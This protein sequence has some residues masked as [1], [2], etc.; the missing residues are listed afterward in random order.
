MKILEKENIFYDYYLKE[1]A[2]GGTLPVDDVDK[3]SDLRVPDVGHDL[4]DLGGEEPGQQLGVGDVVD[5]VVGEDGDGALP[6]DLPVE[7][8]CRLGLVRDLAGVGRTSG[9]AEQS[10]PDLGGGPLHQDQHV[11]PL[12]GE[13]GA[14]GRD[15]QDEVGD[16]V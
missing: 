9:D 3:L 5:K 11:E 10:G 8:G 2:A 14:G 16:E 15:L 6:D 4:P 13:G 12:E 1:E 7:L